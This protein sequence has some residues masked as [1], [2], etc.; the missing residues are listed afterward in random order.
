LFVIVGVLAGVG[1]V[2]WLAAQRLNP[3]VIP[4]VSYFNESVEGLDVGSPIKIRGVKVGIV[5][6]IGIAPDQRMVEVRMEL[7]VRSLRRLGLLPAVRESQA[8]GES[9]APVD[10][11]VQCVS[12]GI[13]GVKFVQADFFDPETHPMPELSFEPGENYVASEPS[14][15][16]SLEDALNSMADVLPRAAENFADL[17]N[18][19]SVTL[20][21][22][23]I[24]ELSGNLTRALERLERR[25]A[26]LDTQALSEEY[27]VVGRQA[28]GAIA[29]FDAPISGL[30]AEDGPLHRALDG[31]ST[32]TANVDSVVA[33]ARLAETTADLREAS[34]SLGLAGESVSRLT[35]DTIDL[36]E[37]LRVTL[38]SL[39]ETLAA[40]Q[41]L[42]TMLERDPGALLHGRSSGAARPRQPK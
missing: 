13:T 40:L 18:Q 21:D 23:H 38:E 7:F 42:A 8:R 4:A 10:L 26:E 11:R 3:E 28:R 17:A 14:T 1:T 22:A 25:L 34:G 9:I 5:S 12:Q 33:E 35:R 31:L 15:L 16:K 29:R 24:G 36:P 2:F 32:L 37:E 41:S 6:D 39:R 27:V 19:V 20:E 30:E